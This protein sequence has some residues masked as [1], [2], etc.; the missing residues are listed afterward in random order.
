[1]GAAKAPVSV[2]PGVDRRHDGLALF[3]CRLFDE[4]CGDRGEVTLAYADLYLFGFGGLEGS[5]EGMESEHG[6]ADT[7]AWASCRLGL[8]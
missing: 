7:T 8:T 4:C 2:H 1:V 6:T 5:D 3:G